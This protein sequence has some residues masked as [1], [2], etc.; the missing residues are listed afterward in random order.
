MVGGQLEVLNRIDMNVQMLNNQPPDNPHFS[1][2][3]QVDIEAHLGQDVNRMNFEDLYGEDLRENHGFTP[4]NMNLL[5]TRTIDRMLPREETALFCGA[6][7]QTRRATIRDG[8]RRPRPPLPAR[9]VVMI[10]GNVNNK[11]L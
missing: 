11:V 9:V 6:E 7:A 8:R 1:R 2:G 10:K 5:A 3:L 4:N